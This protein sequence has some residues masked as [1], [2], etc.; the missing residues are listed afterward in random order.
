MLMFLVLLIFGQNGLISTVYTNYKED[1]GNGFDLEHFQTFDKI[2]EELK[3]LANENTTDNKVFEKSLISLGETFEGREIYAFKFIRKNDNENKRKTMVIE[4]G[5]H[6]REWVS[7]STCVYIITR[8][9]RS[10]NTANTV[11]K[12]DWVLIPVLNPDGYVYTW[13]NSTT[14]MW[15]K[16]RSFT[17]EQMKIYLEKKDD[18]CIGVDINRNFDSNW[19]GPGAPKTPCFTMYAGPK[20][21][22]ENESKALVNFLTDN[23][24][25]VI[26]YISLHTFGQKWMTPFGHSKEKPTNLN[27]MERVALLSVEAIKKVSGLVYTVGS[28]HDIMYP[29]S[30]SSV[31]W[32]SKTLSIPYT[33]LVEMV[34]KNATLEVGFMAEPELMMENCK[35]I[36]I[37]LQ[38]MASHLKNDS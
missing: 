10:S 6:A 31:D 19:G 18:V 25:E 34:P 20:P 24:D 35:T 33:Y 12:Y 13:K 16:N 23:K 17:E 11:S 26:A 8:I 27:E 21:F 4:C 2:V 1:L 32:A 7:V 30:G 22:S 36:W 14:R 29:N 28:S 3:E 5:A 15:R 9:A 37:G 38:A